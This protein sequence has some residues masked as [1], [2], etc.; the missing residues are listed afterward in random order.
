M[1]PALP[2][3]QEEAGLLKTQN[4]DLQTR[5][6][7]LTASLE[8]ATTAARVAQQQHAAVQAEAVQQGKSGAGAA[9]LLGQLEAEKSALEAR[10][11]ELQYELKQAKGS[12]DMNIKS[13]Q[14][15]VADI[16]GT[17]G[18]SGV[19][20]GSRNSGTRESSDFHSLY[21]PRAKAIVSR[22]F[23]RELELFGYEFPA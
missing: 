2:T 12:T 5:V 4:G 14:A 9:A 19:E 11:N 3:L 15:E 8:A 20:I 17:L 23:A 16:C 13:L 10:V 6:A 21:T 1:L 18:I 22:M 7:T